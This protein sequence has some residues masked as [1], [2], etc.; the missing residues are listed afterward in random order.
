MLVP[1]L[2][3]GNQ[4]VAIS[5]RCPDFGRSAMFFGVSHRGTKALRYTYSDW[6]VV[7][8][9]I[10]SM[11][12]ESCIISNC[13]LHFFSTLEDFCMSKESDWKRFQSLIVNVR[14]RYLAEQNAMLLKILTDPKRDETKRFWDTLTQMKNVSKVLAEC[15]D[16]HS[17]SKMEIH[18][19][20]M[21]RVQML[22][23]D[24]LVGFSDELQT[25]MRS[26]E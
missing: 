9:W 8:R 3:P 20:R 14:E 5:E 22:V 26:T 4:K 21:L 18:M 2:Q 25:R 17:R 24:D 11:L 10:A 12:T 23:D 7:R 19:R 16:D 1:R 15:L 13:L 6:I